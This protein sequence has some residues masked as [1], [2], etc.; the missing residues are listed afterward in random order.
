MSSTPRVTDDVLLTTAG[1][2]GIITPEAVVLDLPV[3]NVGSRGVA[4]LIDAI[5]VFGTFFV[6]SFVLTFA[7]FSLGGTSGTIVLFFAVFAGLFVY[8]VAFET[9][10][11]GRTPGKMVMGLRVMTVEGGPVQFR[12]A[13]VRAAV[14]PLDLWA[15][16]GAFAVFSSLITAKS[17]RLGDLAAGTIVIQDRVPGGALQVR[18]FRAPRGAEEFTARLDVALLTEDEYLLIRSL[19]VRDASLPLEQA[20]RLA[21]ELATRLSGRLHPAPPEGMD[22]RSYLTC[23]AAA[24]QRRFATRRDRAV[25][26]WVWAP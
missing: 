4:L 6:L 1:E 22:P 5:I 18:E 15:T 9:V 8:P 16:S 12:H 14:A 3:A 25:S 23:V 10:T 26:D 7:D 24:Y 19:L 21:A 17:Q 20:H 13:A 2:A 11:R